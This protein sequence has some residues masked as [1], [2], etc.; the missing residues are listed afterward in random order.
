MR[1]RRESSAR[2]SHTRERSESRASFESDV[3]DREPGY[4]SRQRSDSLS[5]FKF[6]SQNEVEQAEGA[7]TAPHEIDPVEYEVNRRENEEYAEDEE[8]LPPTPHQHPY[9]YSYEQSFQP[10]GEVF[11]EN[12]DISIRE[13]T[14]IATASAISPLTNNYKD[15]TPL[16]P[17]S[18]SLVESIRERLKSFTITTK[19][20]RPNACNKDSTFPK[21]IS[22]FS[23]RVTRHT[24]TVSSFIISFAFSL[25]VLVIWF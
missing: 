21:R 19:S 14:S 24:S 9:R 16:S 2:R 20:T 17:T 6:F 11:D 25:S 18:L 3:S 22:L 13:T 8:Y 15:G 1:R 7:S 23:L 5:S 4:F 10:S 12:D